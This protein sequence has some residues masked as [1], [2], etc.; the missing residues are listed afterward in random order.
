MWSLT[1]CFFRNLNHT[2]LRCSLIVFFRKISFRDLR[3]HFLGQTVLYK[4]KLSKNELITSS[5]L[6]CL[7]DIFTTCL[8]VIASE[9]SFS[10]CL[11]KIIR[12]TGIFEMVIQTCNMLHW[13]V[14][15]LVPFYEKINSHVW[16]YPKI[17]DQRRLMWKDVKE[18]LDMFEI[19]VFSNCFGN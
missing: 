5:R 14:T 13:H 2:P 7:S 15:L 3:K 12:K 4:I 11:L 1:R 18:N 17:I 9:S 8:Q 16:V 10:R 6:R 19:I